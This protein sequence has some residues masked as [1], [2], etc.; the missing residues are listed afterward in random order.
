MNEYD[1]MLFLKSLEGALPPPEH[2]HHAITYARY[3]SDDTGWEDRLALQV[4]LSR[5]KRNVTLFLE[6]GIIDQKIDDLVGVIVDLTTGSAAMLTQLA[7]H[8]KTC[9]TCSDGVTVGGCSF[10]AELGYEIR[11]ALGKC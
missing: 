10:S 8:C 11:K 9:P 7:E 1:L 6:P 2:C 4:M 5:P 3:G